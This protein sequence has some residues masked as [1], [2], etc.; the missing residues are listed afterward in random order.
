MQKKVVSS[1][2][3]QHVS[4]KISQSV[5]QLK[6]LNHSDGPLLSNLLIFGFKE[7]HVYLYR[8]STEPQ[9]PSI[10]RPGQQGQCRVPRTAFL[11]RC[12]S[13][14]VSQLHRW[15][16][17]GEVSQPSPWGKQ[18]IYDSKR[19]HFNRNVVFQPL[20]FRGDVFFVGGVFSIYLTIFIHT[21][22]VQPP[23]FIGWSRGTTILLMVVD[24]CKLIFSGQF[25][26]AILQKEHPQI[27][28]RRNPKQATR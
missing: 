11:T 12:D 20:F 14:I 10:S 9:I 25:L 17:S 8:P 2:W 28:Q 18:R 27:L 16:S 19:D 21:L 3:S 26:A 15:L 6:R 22:E 4:P 7:P 23:F 13:C 5:Q 24:L 1:W